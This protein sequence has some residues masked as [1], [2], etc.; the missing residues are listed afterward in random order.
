[1]GDRLASPTTSSNSDVICCGAR[2]SLWPL[3]TAGQ[4]A[5]TVA[6]GGRTDIGQSAQYVVPDPKRP[7]PYVVGNCTIVRTDIRRSR[8]TSFAKPCRFLTRQ[9]WGRCTSRS[10]IPSDYTAHQRPNSA[11]GHI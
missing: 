7:T 8:P 9:P 11:S 1:M 3:A 2:G 6:N 5:I 10:H 4:V